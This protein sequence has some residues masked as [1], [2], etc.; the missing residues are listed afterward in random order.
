MPFLKKYYDTTLRS[1]I[2]SKHNILNTFL[3][4]KIGSVEF[5]IKTDLK[6]NKKIWVI[7]FWS[8]FLLTGKK[9]K[10]IKTKESSSYLDSSYVYNFSV[11][12]SKKNMY[13]FL[14]KYTYFILPKLEELE[15]FKNVSNMH[16]YSIEAKGFMNY[17]ETITI[18]NFISDSDLY[19][20]NHLIFNL[21]LH[22][23]TKKHTYNV[24]LVR[25]LQ[26]P[27]HP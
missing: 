9:P 12:L 24:S 7:M 19:L 10:I 3:V 20:I 6:K 4:P 2:I 22:L 26:L 18:Y 17:F 25:G 21:I 27:V 1:L 8:L 5:K 15:S 14:T 11:N 13:F 23:N 16:V